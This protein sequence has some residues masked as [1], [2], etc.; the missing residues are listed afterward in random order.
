MSAPVP[1]PSSGPSWVRRLPMYGLPREVWVLTAVAFFVALGFGILAPAIPVFAKT[2][3]V[4]NL[5]ASSV[6][7]VFA[8][9]RFVSALAGGRL[10]DRFGERVILATGIGI[11]AVSSFVA[12]LSESFPQLLLLR[13]IGGVGSAMFTV[14]ALSLLLRVSAPEQRGQ[15][16]GSFQSGFLLGGIF[17]PAFGGPLTEWSLRAPFFVYAAT[18][19]AAGT[20]AMVFLAHSSLRAKDQ[21]SGAERAP[22][23]LKTAFRSSAYRAAVIN[24]FANGW[25]IFGV[26]A[27]LIPIFVVEGLE[28]GAKWTG[29]GLVVGAVSQVL[30]LIPAGRLADTRGRKPF[31]LAGAALALLAAVVLAFSG[32]V[33]PYLIAMMLFGS[34][35]AMIGVSSAAVVGDVIEGRGGTP[36]A[37]YQMAA[38]AGTFTGPLV[39]GALS[40]TYSYETAFLATA[41]VSVIALLTVLGMPETK[42]REPNEPVRSGSED[43]PP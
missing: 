39:A 18:L 1:S 8:L 7:S 14:S 19:A 41:G 25:S 24:N 28:V 22:T 6:I 13:G 21:K 10:V 37:A 27:A 9:M 16:S 11:V 35:S 17:G 30:V 42:P 4:S 26:R 32:S 2:F 34:A 38:D 20:V 29:I 5:A 33:P 40:D 43:P 31:L 23:S 15:A 36:V 12:G 3:G